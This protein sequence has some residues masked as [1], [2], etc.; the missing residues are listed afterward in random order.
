MCERDIILVF[1]GSIGALEI[2]GCR[3][4]V[5]GLAAAAAIMNEA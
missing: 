4:L 1:R 5:D 3:R 2:M